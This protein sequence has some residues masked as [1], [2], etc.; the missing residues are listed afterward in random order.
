MALIRIDGEGA[1]KDDR[2][3]RA[4]IDT[5]PTTAFAETHSQ[6]AGSVDDQIISA[7]NSSFVAISHCSHL[8]MQYNQH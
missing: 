8:S 5:M 7:A 3:V 2:S 6:A 4:Y 1:I